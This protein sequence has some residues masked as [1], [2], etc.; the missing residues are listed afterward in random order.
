MK[1]DFINLTEEMYQMNIY[2]ASY[3]AG[4]HIPGYQQNEN[5]FQIG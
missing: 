3:A 5:G 4:S 1:N 2:A